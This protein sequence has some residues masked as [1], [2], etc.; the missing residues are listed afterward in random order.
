MK[1]P[2]RLLTVL[3]SLALMSSDLPA[4][5]MTSTASPE[6]YA[7]ASYQQA[8]RLRSEGRLIEAERLIHEALSEFP[9]NQYYQ[10]ELSNVYAAKHDELQRKRRYSEARKMLQAVAIALEQAVMLDESYVP[11]QYNLAVTYKRLGEYERAREKMRTLLAYAAENDMPGVSMNAWLQIG[12]IYEEQ[13]FFYEA[14]QAYLKAKDFNYHDPNI[15]S[16]LRDLDMR[17]K[18]RKLQAQRTAG[19]DHYSQRIEMRSFAQLTG[20]EPLSAQPVSGAAAV[21]F[22]GMML[23]QQFLDHRARR[24]AE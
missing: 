6:D 16:A 21:P 1:L 11:A 10:F 17:E 22:L 7:A 15:E 19:L 24:E 13:G 2:S 23:I 14:R 9:E 8:M 12:S 5:Q 4:A 18:N 20:Q 3:L